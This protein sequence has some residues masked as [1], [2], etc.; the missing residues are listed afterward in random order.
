MVFFAF[1][2]RETSGQPMV[3]SQWDVS[4]V[5][6]GYLSNDPGDDPGDFTAVWRRHLASWY[7][8]GIYNS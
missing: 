2:F 8:N 4:G 6:M 7:I 1:F 5:S 3:F